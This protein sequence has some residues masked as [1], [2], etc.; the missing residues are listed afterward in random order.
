MNQNYIN[1]IALVLDASGSMAPLANELV[2]V[3]DRQIAYLA[4]RS[5][6]LDQET[7]V[8]VYTFNNRTQIECLFYDKDVLRL[9]S[10]K[11]FY[12]ARGMT[13][14]IDATL[15]ALSDLSKTPELYGDHGFLTYVLT[16]GA[17]NDSFSQSTTLANTIAKLKENWTVATFVPNMQGKFEA[18]KFG[19]PPENI[20]IW[21]S[22]SSHGMAEVG[23]VIRQTT[24]NYMQARAVGVRGSRNLF[25]LGRAVGQV[26]VNAVKS[27]LVGL[28]FGQYRTFNVDEVIPIAEFVEA[29]LHRP[30]KT[31]EAYYELT[32]PEKVQASKAIALLERRTKI[33]YVG[34]ETRSLLG[35]PDY[36]VKVAPASHP[37]FDIFVQSTSVNRNLMPN[38][39]VLIP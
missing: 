36:E 26:N 11:G 16:D 12:H 19:F 4:Q 22:T 9:P 31:G 23:E 39:R 27:K 32:K 20:A 10:L 25:D 37:D 35:L 7:R 28:N 29:K 24:E 21:D 17:E 14:L 13:A 8:T 34:A 6:E 38:T 33:L 15:R 3:A 5:K 1:H 18:K 2:K 30:Y